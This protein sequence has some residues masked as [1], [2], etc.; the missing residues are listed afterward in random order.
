MI[1][2]LRII[3]FLF[4][5]AFA[6][7][8][9]RLFFLQVINAEYYIETAGAQQTVERPLEPKRGSIFLS[10][11]VPFAVTARSFNVWVS[12]KD[13]LPEAREDIAAGLAQTLK[14]NKE[15]I[16]ER[17]SKEGDPY[18]PISEGVSEETIAE[19][20]RLNHPAIHWAGADSRHYPLEELGAHILGFLG[21]KDSEKIGQYGLEE[22]YEGLLSGRSGYVEGVRNPFGFIIWPLSKTSKPTDGADLHLTIDYNIQLALERELARASADFSAERANGIIVDPKTGD[23]L[24]MASVPSFNPNKY[25]ETENISLFLNP[26]TQRLFEPGSIFKPITMAVGLDINVVSPDLTYVDT[27]LVEIGSAKIRNATEE[28]YGVQTMT[29]VLEKSLNTGA[30]FVV[31]RIPSGVWREYLERFGLN[32]RTRID[33]AGEIKGDIKNV[34][35]RRELEIATSAFGQGIAVTPVELTMAIAA[36]ANGGELVEPHL[37]E[38]EPKVI[39]RVLKPETAEAVTKMMVSVVESGSGARARLAGYS[40]A[41]KTGTAQIPSSQGGYSEETIHS[42]VGFAPA[43]NP[44]FAMLITLEKPRGVRFAET[45]VGPV[46]R[47]LTEFILHYYG[48]EPDKPLIK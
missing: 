6:A 40:V 48:I 35:S 45:S 24:A 41:G 22:F 42:F 29:Q 44:A 31:R 46:F 18:E 21:R 25:Q 34:S 1:T 30:V 11:G 4:L 43:F 5:I 28:A 37:V 39:R 13:I 23:I 10:G 2:R 16:L 14:Q 47:E 8:I 3:T 36:I 17:I 32:E 20:E 38:Q 19:L 12:P 26:N 15:N 27:G 33:L 9:G 7:T